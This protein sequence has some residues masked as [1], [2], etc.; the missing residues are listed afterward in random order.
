MYKKEEIRKKDDVSRKKGLR[1]AAAIRKYP[2]TGGAEAHNG[3]PD[4][5][6]ERRSEGKR[7]KKLEVTDAGCAKKKM[8][9]RVDFVSGSSDPRSL[10]SQVSEEICGRFGS[11]DGST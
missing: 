11:F 3:T 4:G 1:G 8:A 10:K 6:T 7:G 5:T 9:L 2:L